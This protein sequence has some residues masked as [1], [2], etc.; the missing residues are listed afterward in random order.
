VDEDEIDIDTGIVSGGAG[1]VA[2]KAVSRA[3]EMCMNR[4][5]D[6]LVTAP[7]SKEAIHLAGYLFPGHT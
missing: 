4:D 3:V 5:A 6:A 7:I 1:D 2:M